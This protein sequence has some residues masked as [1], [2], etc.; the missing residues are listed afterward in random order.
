MLTMEKEDLLQYNAFG[1]VSISR[2]HITAS[3]TAVRSDRSFTRSV[4]EDLDI[5]LDVVL[6]GETSTIVFGAW[7]EPG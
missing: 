7:L 3:V 5:P 6:P 2:E 4:V 1:L